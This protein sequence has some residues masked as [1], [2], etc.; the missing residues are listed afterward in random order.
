[1][2][3]N[4]GVEVDEKPNYVEGIFFIKR[5]TLKEICL[6]RKSGGN[7]SLKICVYDRC[8]LFIFGHRTWLRKKIVALTESVYFDR[9]VITL[10]FLASVTMILQDYEDRD[11]EE[12]WNQ[13]LDKVSSVLVVIFSLECFLKIISQGCVMHENSYLRDPWNWIDFAVVITGIME[14]SQIPGVDLKSLRALRVLR[15]L[16]SLKA[17]PRM[18][19]LIQGMI[20]SLPSLL[21]A[22][23]FMG[24]VFLN[25]A[26]FGT[27]QFGGA[28]YTRCRIG[29]SPLE[30]GSWPYDPTDLRLCSTDESSGR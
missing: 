15:P 17:F 11:S 21:N 27:Q 3:F 6:C 25:F 5:K 29:E 13:T 12:L 2:I 22:V 1:M 28:Y 16:R 23:V 4:R 9:A 18:R 14:L 7:K 24:F 8:S 19:K 20:D 10:I 30:D 26:I